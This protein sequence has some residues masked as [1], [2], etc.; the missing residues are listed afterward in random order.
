MA[1][2][3]NILKGQCIW[4]NRLWDIQD[5]KGCIFFETP[6]ILT[7]Q[8]LSSC[9]AWAF[10]V[11]STKLGAPFFKSTVIKFNKLMWR[12]KWVSDKASCKEASLLKLKKAEQRE[13]YYYEAYQHCPTALWT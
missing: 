8:I 5:K 9:R 6:C 2:L 10:Y 11:K 1:I 3:N 12:R 4:P 7:D 13:S